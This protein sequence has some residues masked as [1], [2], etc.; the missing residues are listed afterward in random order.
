V[1]IA[2]EGIESN[3]SVEPTINPVAPFAD[4]R[5]AKNSRSSAIWHCAVRATQWS[6]P[7]RTNHPGRATAPA[8]LALGSK[9]SSYKPT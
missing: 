5:L 2:V 3:K 9:M 1:R 8:V 6:S 7:A 4:H